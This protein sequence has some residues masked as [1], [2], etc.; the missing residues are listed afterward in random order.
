MGHQKRNRNRV[1]RGRR[2]TSGL[3]HGDRLAG[4]KPDHRE[5]RDDPAERLADR[6]WNGKHENDNSYIALH[7]CL[8]LARPW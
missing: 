4:G 2:A 6:M 7:R 8:A 3:G 1:A 5:T